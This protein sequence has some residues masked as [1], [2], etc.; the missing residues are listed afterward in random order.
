MAN[1]LDD[2]IDKL[3]ILPGIGK[4][5]A[6]R[7]AFFILK[8]PLSKVEEFANAI[9]K[10]KKILKPCRLC[11][12][13]AE[14]DICHICSNSKRESSLICVVEEPSDVLVIE[15]AGEYKGIY[16]VLNGALSP[17]DGV[18]PDDINIASLKER[19]ASGIKEIILATNPN[20]EG[21]ATAAYIINMLKPLNIKLTRIARGIPVGGFLEYTDKTTL[22]KALEN[23]TDIV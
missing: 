9:I 19:A 5:S 2:L 6:S 16:H 18:G 1:I 11:G 17:L 21:E 22:S 10:A 15:N 23:R 7:I 12:N 20:T 3:T 8:L 4:K 14:G 13:L